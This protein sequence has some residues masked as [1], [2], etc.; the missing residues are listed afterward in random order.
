MNS[1]FLNVMFALL[2]AVFGVMQSIGAIL[3]IYENS[4]V[5]F[6]K[7]GSKRCECC[8]RETR[9][10]NI[11]Q[12]FNKDAKGNWMKLEFSKISPIQDTGAHS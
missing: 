6:R 8:D 2:G 4:L 10:K 3:N 1:N 5:V 9:C 7:A 11:M 12:C